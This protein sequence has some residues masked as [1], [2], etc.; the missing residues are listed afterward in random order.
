MLFTRKRQALAELDAALDQ[1]A[2]FGSALE[3][4]AGAGVSVPQ[5]LSDLAAEGAPS[6]SALLAAYGPAARAA[7]KADRGAQQTEDLGAR[8]TSFFQSQVGGRSVTRREGDDT[9]AVLSRI[10]DELR[11]NRLGKALAEAQ[12]LSEAAQVPL[13]TWL[14][15]LRQLSLAH[16]A[17]ADVRAQVETLDQ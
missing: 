16:D 5:A 3:V 12:G 14:D 7:L 9:D 8:L 1:G 17:L 15:K 13:G 4:L 10:E 6:R 11:Q 2:P